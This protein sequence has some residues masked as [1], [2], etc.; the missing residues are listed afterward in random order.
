MYYLHKQKLSELLGTKESKVF[1]PDSYWKMLKYGWRTAYNF[2]Y[3]LEP[4][5][6]NTKERNQVF[7]I[8]Q[9]FE[10]EFFPT[11]ILCHNGDI[12]TASGASTIDP[13]AMA[14]RSGM[15]SILD[16]ESLEVKEC[17]T[18]HR[19]PVSRLKCNNTWIV[20][21]SVDNS[22]IKVWDRENFM[23]R[24]EIE[25]QQ[26]T[27]MDLSEDFIFYCTDKKKLHVSNTLESQS[28]SLEVRS[29]NLSYS[30][31]RLGLNMYNN[32]SITILDTMSLDECVS[33]ATKSKP[34][35]V[36]LRHNDCL[37]SQKYEIS[38]YDIR[39]QERL[40][41]IETKKCIPSSMYI[42]DYKLIYSD[43]YAYLHFVDRRMMREISTLDPHHRKS[44]YI[45]F[46][47]NP[48]TEHIITCGNDGSIRIYN[49]KT[50]AYNE[51]I[52]WSSSSSKNNKCTIQ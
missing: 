51:D 20:T 46:C 36:L 29:R 9:E 17:Y 48:L 44:S 24:S 5:K 6:L 52:E 3:L 11:R 7:T 4:E 41:G 45:Q 31:H 25:T 42:D 8:A 15:V 23:Y 30:D 2:K 37:I 14:S 18:A 21:T 12:I 49:Y 13:I 38:L 22:M 35:R 26:I 1:L 27:S 39:G 19:F 16:Y 47:I 10:Y 43:N 34:L 28:K 33:Y 50:L 40:Q 32:N